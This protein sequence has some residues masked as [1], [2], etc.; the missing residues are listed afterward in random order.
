[1]CPGAVVIVHVR[2]EHM[3]Q[4]PLA[5]NDD[6]V[7]TFPPDSGGIYSNLLREDKLRASQAEIVELLLEVVVR[8]EGPDAAPLSSGEASLVDAAKDSVNNA[9]RNIDLLLEQIPGPALRNALR[10]EFNDALFYAYILGNY[11]T[12]SESIWQLYRS[13]HHR[14]HTKPATNAR[15]GDGDLVQELVEKLTRELWSQ[16]PLFTGNSNGT[17]TEIRPAFN[18]DIRQWKSIPN[19]WEPS[20]SDDSESVKREIDRIRRRV[21]RMMLPDN[22]RSSS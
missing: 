15:K 4:V 14:Q 21:S 11:S 17:A 8:T 5:K 6:M 1:M 10:E 19:G 9:S 18:R 22:R 12:P 7:K 16:K 2:K 20:D 13:Q 3:A